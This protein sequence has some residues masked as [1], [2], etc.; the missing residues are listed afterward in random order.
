MFPKIRRPDLIRGSL[1]LPYCNGL[2]Q[3]LP[4]HN[5]DRDDRSAPLT[6]CLRQHWFKSI[7]EARQII[8]DWR[9]DYNHVRPHS[10]LGQMA[11]IEALLTE[12]FNRD[13]HSEYSG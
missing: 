2:C 3:F 1:T 12:M 8:E 4:D 11:P 13:S 5:H 9:L 7:N 10:A 6:E